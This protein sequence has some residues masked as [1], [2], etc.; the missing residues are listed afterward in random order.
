MNGT[1]SIYR[2][3]PIDKIFFL[4]VE[5]QQRHMAGEYSFREG[6]STNCIVSF[7]NL[8][9]NF[10]TRRRPDVLFRFG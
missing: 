2:N 3:K 5:Y 6:S 4:Q 7:Q 1:T 9:T 10:P 8:F